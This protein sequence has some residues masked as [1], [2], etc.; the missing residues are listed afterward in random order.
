MSLVAN[1]KCVRQTLVYEC[2]VQWS[3]VGCERTVWKH[4][5]GAGLRYRRPV[6]CPCCWLHTPELTLVPS[7]PPF[8]PLYIDVASKGPPGSPNLAQSLLH[9]ADLAWAPRHCPAPRL[10]S[11]HGISGGQGLP[12]LSIWTA[13]RLGGWTPWWTSGHELPG[14]V[15]ENGEPPSRGRG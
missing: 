4:G 5:R 6:F 9:S 3:G 12:V 10:D 8:P 1:D 13:P 15:E 7:E 11:S 14:G 2:I